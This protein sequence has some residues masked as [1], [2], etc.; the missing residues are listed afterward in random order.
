MTSPDPIGVVVC[1]AIRRRLGLRV[2]EVLPS[3]H[4]IRDLA[5]DS[6]DHIEIALSVEDTFDIEVTDDEVA[7]CATV[8]DWIALVERKL[9]A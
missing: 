2:H 1:T 7:G 6:M 9:G 3:H 8:A 4:L 5:C